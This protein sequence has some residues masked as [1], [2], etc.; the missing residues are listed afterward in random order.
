[1]SLQLI[2]PLLVALT[3]ISAQTVQF[4]TFIG[5]IAGLSYSQQVTTNW[6][7]VI[8]FTAL[9]PVTYT[10]DATSVIN[11]CSYNNANAGSVTNNDGLWPLDTLTNNELTTFAFVE[12]M[13]ELASLVGNPSAP[14]LVEYTDACVGTFTFAFGTVNGIC[15]AD[16]TN[17]Y[18]VYDDNAAT[19]VCYDLSTSVYP[20]CRSMLA[21]VTTGV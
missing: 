15:C 5:G 4:E 8:S 7:G 18:Y 1:M 9:S 2:V 6:Y 13:N 16:P 10:G 19:L 14:L 3:P 17:V 21:P 20:V 12:G 11:Y